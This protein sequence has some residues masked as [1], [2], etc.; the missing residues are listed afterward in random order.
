MV[1]AMQPDM[2]LASHSEKEKTKTKTK[3][4]FLFFLAGVSGHPTM[5]DHVHAWFRGQ[6][7]VQAM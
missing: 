5:T 7:V 1:Y 4:F 2:Q 6:G 3:F